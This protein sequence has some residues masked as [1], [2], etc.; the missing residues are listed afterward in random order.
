[1]LRFSGG[2]HYS[3]DGKPKA[4]TSHPLPPSTGSGQASTGSGSLETAE[5]AE[6]LATDTHRQPQTR[7]KNRSEPE[8][9]KTSRLFSSRSCLPS[10]PAARSAGSPLCGPLERTRFSLGS[11]PAP[12][13]MLLL[14]DSTGA[15]RQEG[16]S[17]SV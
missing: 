15:S 7:S 6:C 11:L 10:T 17:G 5:N 2:R 1:M 4:F 9:K 12:G 3:H 14:F 8:C 16:S 13:G